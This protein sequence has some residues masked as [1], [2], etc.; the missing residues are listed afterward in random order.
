MV[1]HADFNHNLVAATSHTF[2]YILGFITLHGKIKTEQKRNKEH[3]AIARKKSCLFLNK[4][5]QGQ[6]SFASRQYAY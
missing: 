5:V 6:S 3:A 4:S 1:L 2:M